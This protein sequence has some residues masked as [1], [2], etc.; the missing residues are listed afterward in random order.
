MG[1]DVGLLELKLRDLCLQPFLLIIERQSQAL[2]LLV[3]GWQVGEEAIGVR[4]CQQLLGLRLESRRLVLLS[5]DVVVGLE[6][7]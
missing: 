4:D 6:D 3:A 2:T 7:S 5:E 1:P